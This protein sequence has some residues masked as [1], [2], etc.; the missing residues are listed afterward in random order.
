M[1][2]RTLLI[3]TLI[4][5]LLGSCKK[6][7]PTDEPGLPDKPGN[8]DTIRVSLAL[9]IDTVCFYKLPWKAVFRRMDDGNWQ[10][11]HQHHEYNL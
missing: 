2:K 1:M 7:G 4:A 6:Q 8:E 5:M 11:A 3:A 10:L 9:E